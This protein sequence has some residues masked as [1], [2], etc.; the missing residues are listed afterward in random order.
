MLGLGVVAVEITYQNLCTYRRYPLYVVWL[1][2]RYRPCGARCAIYAASS[3]PGLFNSVKDKIPGVTKEKGDR[4]PTVADRQISD[5]MNVMVNVE[6][7]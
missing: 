5:V 2:C 4:M 1:L 3:Q 7:H 6:G